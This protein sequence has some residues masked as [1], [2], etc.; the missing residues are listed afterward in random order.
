[1]D[2]DDSRLLIVLFDILAICGHI[3]EKNEGPH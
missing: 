3:R 1:M 2:V